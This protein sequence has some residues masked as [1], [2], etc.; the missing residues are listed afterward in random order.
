MM[1]LYFDIPVSDAVFPYV[2]LGGAVGYNH[3]KLEYGNQSVSNHK[4]NP[5]WQV[6]AGI[7]YKVN[8]KLFTDLGYRYSDYGHV[9]I[10]REN[11]VDYTLDKIKSHSLTLG[12][13]YDFSLFFTPRMF[14]P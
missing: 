3:V 7:S 14:A 2:M 8:Q 13:R 9:D 11:G 4:M 5:A 6:G 10:I 12:L 1:N